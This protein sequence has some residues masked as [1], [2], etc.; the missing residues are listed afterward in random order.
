VE[1]SV[2]PTLTWTSAASQASLAESYVALA[3]HDP[4][5]A[6]AAAREVLT[7]MEGPLPS[8]ERGAALRQLGRAESQLGKRS[9]AGEHSAASLSVFETVQSRPERAQTLLALGQHLVDEDPEASRARL[10]QATDL[11]EATGAPGWAAEAKAA[12]CQ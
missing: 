8:L 4:E 2:E 7:L 11:F 3:R 5:R 6:A 10:Q 1:I 9:V 12:L